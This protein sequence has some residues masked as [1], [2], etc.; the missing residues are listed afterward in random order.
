MDLT[1]HWIAGLHPPA[2]LT[3]TRDTVTTLLRLH[4]ERHLL[5]VILLFRF[6]LE[7][8]FQWF[9]LDL[10]KWRLIPCFFRDWLSLLEEIPRSRMYRTRWQSPIQPMRFVCSFW[11]IGLRCCFAQERSPF[12]LGIEPVGLSLSLHCFEWLGTLH[13]TT[14]GISTIFSIVLCLITSRSSSFPA[15][16]YALFACSWL[17]SFAFLGFWGPFPGCFFV[18]VRP[19]LHCL[20][21]RR[22]CPRGHRSRSCEALFP[23]ASRPLS[24]YTFWPWSAVDVS[25]FATPISS[26]LLFVARLQL[27][28]RLLQS[29]LHFWPCASWSVGTSRPIPHCLIDWPVLRN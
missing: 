26:W 13:S 23:R 28:T 12:E 15:V 7:D 10:K 2:L 21:H 24:L 9:V 6:T 20:R 3:V 25:W 27:R 14:L 18:W 16:G 5:I 11:I 17:C 4:L 19:C 8:N 22:R 29:S 1:H